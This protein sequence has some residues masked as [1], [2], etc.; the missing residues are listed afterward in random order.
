MPRTELE[1]TMIAALWEIHENFDCVC[2]AMYMAGDDWEGGICAACVSGNA[3]KAVT[4][5]DN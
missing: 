4:A 5:A 3:L 2:Q 1:K